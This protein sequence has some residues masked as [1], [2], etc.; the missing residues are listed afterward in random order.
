M[1]SPGATEF[2]NGGSKFHVDSFGSYCVKHAVLTLVKQKCP[3]KYLQ[4]L[5]KL[6]APLYK[7]KYEK[8][9]WPKI[10]SDPSRRVK[11]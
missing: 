5:N 8:G 9:W 7:E 2:H 1:Y 4:Q 11:N 6:N 10:E 3:K